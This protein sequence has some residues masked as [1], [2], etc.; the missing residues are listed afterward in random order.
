MKDKLR[1]A[2]EFQK[3]LQRFA[4]AAGAAFCLLAFGITWWIQPSFNVFSAHPSGNLR[5]M[6]S[7]YITGMTL[8]I[9]FIC[10]VLWKLTQGST[11]RILNEIERQ[12]QEEVSNWKDESCLL[13]EK[14]HAVMDKEKALEID[15]QSLVERNSIIEE[16]KKILM[17]NCSKLQTFHASVP[18]LVKLMSGHLSK[19][20]STAEKASVAI[21]Q[22]LTD[23]ETEATH[24]LATLDEGRKR[25]DSISGNAKALLGE[26]RQNLEELQNY[27]NQRTLQIQADGAAIQNV[28]DQV[29]ALKPLTG[30][31]R[32]V[33]M[34]TNLL[35]LNAAIEA[36]RAGDSGRGFAVVA[37]EVRKLSTQVESA[38]LQIE[39]SVT[40]VSNT[41]NNK[42]LSIVAQS[43]T[44][45]ESQWF[46]TLASTM[47][48]SSQDFEHAVVELGE[49]SQHTHKAVDSIRRDIIGVLGH[50]QFQDITRQ[51]IEQVINGIELC[52][53][54]S[55]D[56]AK[57]LSNGRI[58][59]L[60]VPS[61]DDTM[62]A[63]RASY[64]MQ[65]QRMT[66]HAIVGGKSADVGDERPAIELF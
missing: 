30:L 56:V 17:E 42:L 6:V 10:T 33:T 49:V 2:H 45:S 11:E 60:D 46:S 12:W 52:A 36:A 9:V 35:A 54:H 24:L 1:E 13:E 21:I 40:Q 27:R 50:T 61:L 34:Q 4:L 18:P 7:M 8:M 15:A 29:A 47:T 39:E 63:L 26:S 25:A 66:H 59:H 62:E 3:R 14:K 43:R 23:V 31:I 51:Q 57:E 28:V 38:A 20:D 55:G 65:S 58:A 48:R 64:T 32:D 37:D 19:A 53:Q 22:G 5:L 44:D 41:V 16:E